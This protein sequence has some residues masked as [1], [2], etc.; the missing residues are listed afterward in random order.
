MDR[1]IIGRLGSPFGVK[2]WIKVISFTDPREKILEYKPWQLCINNQWQRIEILN[3]QYQGKSIIVQLA[4]LQDREIAKTYTHGEIAIERNQLPVLPEQDY[5]W[6]DLIGLK[7]ITK[8][9]EMLGLVNHLIATG[10]NDVLVVKG[11]RERLI[12]YVDE[13]IVQVDLQTKEITVDW[14]PSF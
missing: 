7:V 2:G 5:Y 3:S 6:V 9:G 12:P 8:S 14:D 13:V 4:G 11:D 10:S 1:I